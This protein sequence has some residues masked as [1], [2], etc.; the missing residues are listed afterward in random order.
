V[1]R[2]FRAILSDPRVAAVAVTSLLAR[3]PKG[4]VP[5]ATVLLLH[6]RTGSY[7]LAGLTTALVAI[8]DAATTPAQGRLVDRY[9]R[10]KVLVPTAL[11]H[12]AAV[13]VLL[14]A[15]A[16]MTLA[17]AACVAGVGMP[18][19]SGS[20]KAVWPRLVP[21]ELVGA[22]YALESLMQQAF[23]LT[24]PLLVAAI[25]KPAVALAG[26]AVLLLTGTVGF[27]AAA[28][29]VPV[30][31]T[32]G[33][34]GG[35]LRIPTVRRLVGAN[36]LQ[37]LAFGAGPVGIVALTAQTGLPGTAGVLQAMLTVGGVLGTFALTVRGSYPRLLVRF[38]AALLPIP[39]FAVFGG[40]LALFG[41]GAASIAAGLLLTPIAAVSYL[42]I[43]RETPMERRT[44]AFAWLSTGL[45]IG[46]AA[47]SALAGVLV[48]RVGPA[49]ALAVGPVMVGLAA[50]ASRSTKWG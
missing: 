28:G 10:T 26:S 29:S 46:S 31:P 44:E 6:Q 20:I 38:A 42:L 5:L 18:P 21:E 13:I 43:E 27:V 2:Q 41:V 19:I 9:G 15:S 50:I 14:V 30:P 39:L 45:A 40:P 3:L 32:T 48:D 36:L 33:G 37:S 11:I 17:A 7:T 47:G 35:A 8:G 4:M 24:G 25:G 1:L 22:A 49:G 23:F 34:H 12:V 16:P